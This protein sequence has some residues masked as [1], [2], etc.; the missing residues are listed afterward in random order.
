VNALTIEEKIERT[1]E[2]L[3]RLT[4]V[5]DTL[6]ASVIAHD[7]QIEVLIKIS[8]QNAREWQQLRKE[9]QAYLNTLPKH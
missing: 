5:V 4:G 9:F 8:E 1:A 2:N 3:N 6:A 7:Q